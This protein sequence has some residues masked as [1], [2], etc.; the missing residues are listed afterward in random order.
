MKLIFGLTG[1]NCSGKNLVADYLAKHCGFNRFSVREMIGEELALRDL[2]PTRENLIA[3]GNNL[4]EQEGVEVWVKKAIDKARKNGY[5][6]VA[7]ESLR[8]PGEVHYLRNLPNF[9]LIGVVASPRVR[10]TRMKLRGALGDP[11]TWKEFCTREAQDKGEG[12]K[13][14]GQ[15]IASCMKLT[16]FRVLNNGPKENTYKLIDSIIQ[17]FDLS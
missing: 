9:Y 16:D 7:I 8:N 15:Q 5:S 17:K 14:T 1:F 6:Q 4:R 3:L 10:F 12:E 11:K 13:D 2:V